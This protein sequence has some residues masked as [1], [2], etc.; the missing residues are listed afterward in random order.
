MDLGP[1]GVWSGALR[2]GARAAVLEA[3]EADP[4]RA[5]AIA[6][7]SIERYLNAPNHAA[8]ADHVC[9]QVLTQTPQ[10]LPA[11]M[12]GWRQLAAVFAS[13]R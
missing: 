1:F 2:N 11:A 10:D 6:R 7:P 3:A 5:R 4:R 12:T 13:A 8:G 9:I